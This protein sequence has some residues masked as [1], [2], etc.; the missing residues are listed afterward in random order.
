MTHIEQHKIIL[1]LKDYEHKMKR[2]DQ[3]TFAM[4]A[5]RDKDDEDLD[6]HSRTKLLALYEVYV[7]ARLR[8]W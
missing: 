7:P 8:N 4:F 5:K 3:E 6:S 2:S 1:E